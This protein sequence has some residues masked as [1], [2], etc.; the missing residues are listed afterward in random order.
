MAG[1]L[2]C[3]ARYSR[4]RTRAIG[5][6]EARRVPGGTRRAWLGDCWR[7]ASAFFTRSDDIGKWRS[8]LPVSCATAFPPKESVFVEHYNELRPGRQPRHA[9]K[10]LG[11]KRILD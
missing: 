5:Q 11:T 7:Y 6:K 3:I 9:I 10:C 8:R 4:R 1:L 2:R